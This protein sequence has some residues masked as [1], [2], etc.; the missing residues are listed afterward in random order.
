MVMADPFSA[1]ATLR[2]LT[3]KEEDDKRKKAEKVPGSS[4]SVLEACMAI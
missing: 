2:R 3:K 1:A 4:L